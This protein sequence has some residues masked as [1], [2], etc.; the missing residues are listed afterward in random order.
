M[1]VKKLYPISGGSNDFNMNFNVWPF[2]SNETDREEK[3]Y[4]LLHLNGACGY[5]YSERHLAIEHPY[6]FDFSRQLE[7][8]LSF[9]W[10]DDDNFNKKTFT[11]KRLPLAKEM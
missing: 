11:D 6:M 4:S 2:K 7:P 5:I 1:G 10:E 3:T 9:A 8:I